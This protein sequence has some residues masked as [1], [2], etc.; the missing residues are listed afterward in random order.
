MNG[1]LVP[2]NK[3]WQHAFNN[4]ISAII[5]TISQIPVLKSLPYISLICL[6]FSCSYQQLFAQTHGTKKP[7]RCG[8]T[9]YYQRLFTD[10]VF[11]QKFEQNQRN[12]TKKAAADRELHMDFLSDTIPVVVHVLVDSSLQLLVTDAII[13]SQVDVLNEDYQG[14][15]VDSSRIPPAFKPFFGKSNLHFQLTRTNPY[16]EP[17]TGISRMPSNITYGL[18][19]LD[20]AKQSY[21]GGED[22]WDPNRYLNIW[23][24]NFGKSG[25]LGV[26]VYPGDPRPLNVHGFICDYRAFGRGAAYLD[27][28][29]NGGK[30]TTHELGHFFNLYHIWG[31]DGGACTGTDFPKDSTDDDTP[32]QADN[33]YGNPDSTDV[34]RI[35]TDACSPAPPGIMYQNYMD[36]TDDIDLV[37]FTQGQ[38]KRMETSLTAS[39]DRLQLLNSTTYQPAAVYTR[40]ARIWQILNP[41]PFTNCGAITPK[42]IL[43]NSGT[44]KLTTVK[45]VSILNGNT[46]IVYNWT[47]SLSSYTST[48][49]NLPSITAPEGK[50]ILK[51]YTVA[52]N[53]LAD[54]NTANDTATASFTILP[55]QTLNGTVIEGF[56]RPDFPPPGWQ[57]NN[58]DKD[59]TWSWNA[60]IGNKH[61]GS[62]WFNDWNNPT[63]YRYDDLITPTYSYNNTDSVFLKFNLAAATYSDPNTT[64]IPI[65]TL[66][67]LLSKDCGNTFTTI[68]KKWGAA[69]QTTVNPDQA[70]MDEFF[71]SSSQ[72]RRD[73]VNLGA[74][75][76][77]TEAQVRLAFRF[78]GNNENNLFID[79]V[80]L[81]TIVLPTALKQQGFL[82]LPTVFSTQFGIWHYQ[83]PTTLKYITIFNAMG[84]MVWQKQ[85]NGN[86]DKFITVNLSRQSAGVYFV[87]LGYNDAR[88]NVTQRIIKY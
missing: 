25:L 55:V 23:V 54:Q 11:K 22:A 19:T 17:T 84:Q 46:P 8:T 83:Q 38:Q 45:I 48:I 60:T 27:S 53:N 64:T 36:Y 56:D 70:L 71:P 4:K 63:N 26:S 1:T 20:S 31:D 15:N 3:K 86:A 21:T 75:L 74:Y 37:M 62:A 58:P 18:N 2:S 10:P 39:P 44:E 12:I 81:N 40:D 14:I 41:T 35:I 51:I 67:V 7:I 16:G 49:L 33:T 42:I 76:N 61:P 13:Q 77:T 73:S 32:N 47:G 57:V 24:V 72:W 80:T 85:F 66:T 34:G 65:D 69:L 52:P 68:Y 29:Y 28:S 78:S 79:D 5:V 9:A 6:I 30:T 59:T 82:L 43:R 50:N 88:R 87:K